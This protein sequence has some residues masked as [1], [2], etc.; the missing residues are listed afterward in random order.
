MP[1][2]RPDFA[3]PVRFGLGAFVP[4]VPDLDPPAVEGDVLQAAPDCVGGS[5]GH[6]EKRE[7]AFEFDLADL[8]GTDARMVAHQANDGAF[9]NFI[10]ATDV[11]EKALG[12]GCVW[13]DLAAITGRATGSRNSPPHPRRPLHGSL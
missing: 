4:G 12:S 8:P 3:D 10:Q 2:S 5:A 6:F 9:I 11:D 1:D 7:F 13:S